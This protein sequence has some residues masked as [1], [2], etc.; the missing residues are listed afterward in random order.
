M[1][2]KRDVE[3][4]QNYEQEQQRQK[5]QRWA[6]THW[7]LP[8]ETIEHLLGTDLKEKSSSIL[9][10]TSPT[11]SLTAGRKSFKEFNPLIEE[12]S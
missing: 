2:R 8:K 3:L 9:S 4:Q 11:S 6:D 12:V 10:I 1:R 7:Q 5:H